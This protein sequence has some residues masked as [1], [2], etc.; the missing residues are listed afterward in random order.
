MTKGNFFFTLRTGLS[1]AENVVD[2]EQ[3]ILAL[4]WKKKKKIWSTSVLNFNSY[5]L[6]TEVLGNSQGSESDTGAGTWGLVHLT[7]HEGGLGATLELDDTGEDHL[8]VEIVTL[9]GALTDT[10]EDGVTTVHLIFF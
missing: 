10:T 5:L 2:E 3:H 4:K 9:T 7:V 6:V 1:E 8:V